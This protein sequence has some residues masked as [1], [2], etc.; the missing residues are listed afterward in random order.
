MVRK[1]LIACLGNIFYGDDGF[2]ALVAEE[3]SKSDLP[4]NAAVKDFGIRGIELA[5]E[6]ANDYALVILI[7]VLEVGASA[8]SVFVFETK[9][10]I[11]EPEA[12]PHDL[13]PLKAFELARALGAKNKKTLI[14]GCQPANM[15]FGDEMSEAVKAAVPR[16]VEKVLEILNNERT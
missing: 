12:F 2:G 7:D 5:F 13:T 16:A 8:G 6:L 3:L 11:A 1:I 9:T 14:V 4:E 15:N 10:E